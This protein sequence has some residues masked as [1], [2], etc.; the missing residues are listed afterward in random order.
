MHRRH[1]GLKK[2]WPI[3]ANLAVN[4]S[5][6]SSMFSMTNSLPRQPSSLK[7]SSGHQKSEAQLPSWWS[8]SPPPPP[9]RRSW[10]HRQTL[11]W[12]KSAGSGPPLVNCPTRQ[13]LL[14]FIGSLH[15][16]SSLIVSENELLKLAPK[17]FNYSDNQSIPKYDDFKNFEDHA[18]A[19]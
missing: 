1:T 4:F 6:L 15:W 19:I 2:F 8:C 17:Y 12:F 5:L 7:L 10:P 11:P 18:D 13:S 14:L 16:L 9:W 3:L